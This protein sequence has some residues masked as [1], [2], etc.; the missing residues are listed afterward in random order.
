MKRETVVPSNIRSIGYD[1]ITNMLDVEF[2]SGRVYQYTHVPIENYHGIMAAESH[3]KYLNRLIKN[4]YPCC[5][6]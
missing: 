3:E 4:K 1:Q 2:R 6:V 5:E